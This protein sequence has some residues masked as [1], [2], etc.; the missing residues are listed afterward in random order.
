MLDINLIREK[1]SIVREN[2]SRRS[3][4]KLLTLLDGVIRADKTLREYI[5]KAN[6][7]K[8]ARNILTTEISELLKAKKDA[9]QKIFEAKKLQDEI[10]KLDYKI[11][12]AKEKVR[13]LLMRLPNLLD[14]S[15]PHGESEADNIIVREWGEKPKLDFPIKDHVDL[16]LELDLVDLERAAKVSGARF[17]YLKRELVELNLAI[18]KFALDFMRARGFELY[19]PPYMLHRFGVECAT[20]LTDF[21]HMIYKIDGED[22]Y[23]LPTAEH[24]LLALHANEIFEEK[25]L[26]RHY[27]GISPCFRKEAGAH[28]RD[29]KGI[30]RVHQFE[31]VE[32]FVF[33]KPEDSW[34]ELEFILA[35]AEEFYR[36]LNLSHR[37]V[38]IC[39]GEIGTVAAKK[40][41]IEVWFP[42]QGKYREVVSCSNCTDYQARRANI[43]FRP[44]GNLPTRFVH[45]LNS[46]LVA[47]ERTLAAILENYQQRDGTIRIPDALVPYLNGLRKIR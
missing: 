29:T 44:A 13:F 38:N 12:E 36:K 19:Q 1:P 3:D 24:A 27:A 25:S 26:P 15:V 9:S 46:T 35:N 18:Q 11:G 14:E 4:S 42:G 22:S 28:G 34:R 23:L 39:T 7:L 10:K 31:K 16:A 45:T 37:I 6:E 21:E 32:Q 30:F 47:S 17:Y 2:L 33:C 5:T 43:R 8:R 20:D 41:D 40:Y